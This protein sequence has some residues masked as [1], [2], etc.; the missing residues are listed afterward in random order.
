MIQYPS[1]MQRP[2]FERGARAVLG[3]PIENIKAVISDE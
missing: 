2:I 1:L 3:R